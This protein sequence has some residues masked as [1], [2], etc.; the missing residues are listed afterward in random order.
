MTLGF[1]SYVLRP[2]KTELIPINQFLKM[3]L[4]LFFSEAKYLQGHIECQGQLIV[5]HLLERY[6]S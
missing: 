6:I 3:S 4:S 2:D 5:G 1:K